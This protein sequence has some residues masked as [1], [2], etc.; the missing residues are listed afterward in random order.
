MQ[1]EKVSMY[2][3]KKRVVGGPGS[4]CKPNRPLV[5]CE[6]DRQTGLSNESLS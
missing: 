3:G 1:E 6:S 5:G 4:S 2:H